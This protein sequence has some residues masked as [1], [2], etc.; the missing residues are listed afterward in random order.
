MLT[1]TYVALYLKMSQDTHS[2]YILPSNS[3][4]HRTAPHKQE[5]RTPFR[6][7]RESPY[8]DIRTQ[9]SCPIYVFPPPYE[10]YSPSSES[11][12]FTLHVSYTIFQKF[13]PFGQSPLCGLN[14]MRR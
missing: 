11:Q 8:D 6:H 14:L 9:S 3:T 1:A 13:L 12:C 7:S 5:S 4:Q 10:S 2:N